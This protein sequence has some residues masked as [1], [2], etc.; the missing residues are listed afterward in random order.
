MPRSKKKVTISDIAKK[1]GV[2][3][4][5]VSRVLNKADNVNKELR[6]KVLKALTTLGYELDIKKKGNIGTV[7][8]VIRELE[9]DPTQNVYFSKILSGAQKRTEKLGG[10]L[11]YT[12]VPNTDDKIEEVVI[13]V[14]NLKVDALL[15]VNLSNP[16]LVEELLKL[17]IPSVVME[18]YFP[19][20]KVDC[21]TTDAFDGASKVAKF[22]LEKHQEIAFIDGPQDQYDVVQRAAG[23]I[24]TLERM[25][26]PIDPDLIAYSDLL[27]EGGYRAMKEI[28][29]KGKKFTAVYC[30]ND[31]SAIGAIRAI[32]EYGLR[33]PE[34]ISIVGND[35]IDMAAHLDPPL[36]TVR[37]FRDTLGKVAV[38]RLYNKILNPYDTVLKIVI[39]EEL[40]IRKS[41][42]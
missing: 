13:K 41:T 21:I 40:V 31:H 15:L 17:S 36:T 14:K 7:G 42:I 8:F 29:S 30:T 3:V 6:E 2:S 27:P 1:A 16:K 12:V 32:K 18:D 37:V 19:E 10:R 23:F 11:I 28:L 35:D 25:G 33:I 9:D 4:G 24:F 38:D 39:P 22:L 34:D 20:L 5:T 26:R